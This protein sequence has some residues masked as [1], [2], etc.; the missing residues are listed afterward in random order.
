MKK[1]LKIVILLSVIVLLATPIC[2]FGYNSPFAD[3]SQ[4]EWYAESVEYVDKNGLMNGTADGVF[5]PQSNVTR[6]MI[7]TILYRYEG[8]PSV[9]DETVF[10][11]V[12]NDAYYYNPVIWANENGI[13]NGYTAEIFRP[14]D[15]ITR[16]QFA[17]I[18]Y[19]YV[20]HKGFDIA[21]KNVDSLLT[22]YDDESSVSKYAY[23]A[24]RWA[25]GNGIIN[26]VTDTE[27]SPQGK[28]TRAQ[29]ATIFMR[30]DKLL[31][32]NK[33][34]ETDKEQISSA[35]GNTGDVQKEYTEPTLVLGKASAK[36]G[37]TVCITLTIK[38]NPGFAAAILDVEYDENVLVLEKINFAKDYEDGGEE[39]NLNKNPVR[40]VW[41]SLENNTKDS[42][43]A[44][45][46][47]KVND[48]A[49]SDTVTD[50]RLSY[51]KGNICNLDEN[52]VLFDV[53]DG[54]V[55]IK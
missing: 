45:L 3:V 32:E 8:S 41:S 42:E 44:I 5:D 10:T 35:N 14:N 49:K 12:R 1:I 48:D 31:S 26:G 33:Q 29:T 50:I 20:N 15:E 7:V 13:V 18:V 19:R 37:E 17:A 54:S 40:I 28:T 11:D 23:T 4:N 34:V 2:C 24:M 47:F 6:A 43:M 30:L 38:N 25:N 55:N 46:E 52:D 9:K 22:S 27:L 21:R 39:A 16:E 53:I 36:P 51:D